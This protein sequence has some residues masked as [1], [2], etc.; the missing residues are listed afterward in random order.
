MRPAARMA[1]NEAIEVNDNLR[2]LPC[3][4][5]METRGAEAATRVKRP[6]PSRQVSAAARSQD[7]DMRPSSRGTTALLG[8]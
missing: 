6:P 1:R 2:L 7:W 8:R 4:P 5:T 3:V